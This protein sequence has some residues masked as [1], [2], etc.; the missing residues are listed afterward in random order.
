[1]TLGDEPQLSKAFIAI[2]G[3]DALAL[4][5][6]TG[7]PFHAVHMARVS[8]D[9]WQLIYVSCS[10]SLLQLEL[11]DLI[12]QPSSAVESWCRGEKVHLG[13]TSQSRLWTVFDCGRS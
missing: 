4:S 6:E 9:N 10:P 13:S 1:M 2:L 8:D 11:Q 7:V 3:D 5:Q 12:N